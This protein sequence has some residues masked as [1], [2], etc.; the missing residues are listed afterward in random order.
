MIILASK[1]PRRR[2]MMNRIT[3]SF[4]TY[5]PE[6]NED[7][8]LKLKNPRE[9]VID[10]AKRKGL[11]SLKHY[12]DDIIIS[13]DTIVVLDNE[14]IGKP[15]NEED[16]KKILSHLS[17]K[18]HLVITGYIIVSKEKMMLNAVTSH[19]QMYDLTDKQID[20]YVKS[21]S[22]LDKA[23]AYGIQDNSRYQIVRSYIGSFDNIKGFPVEEIR[24]DLELFINEK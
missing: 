17:D 24:R 22:P 23:G 4:L 21:G 6:I 9:I 19:V 3:S 20:E 7:E 11:E 12:P 16:A 18:E 8:S 14:I 1:S 15:K 13:A 10:I 2:E 5:T